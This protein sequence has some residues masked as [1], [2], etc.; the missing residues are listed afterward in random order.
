MLNFFYI[1]KSPKE[2]L[3]LLKLEIKEYQTKIKSEEKK[4]KLFYGNI[5]N[6]G[7]GVL[8]I[9]SPPK[10][11]FFESIQD[12]SIIVLMNELKIDKFFITY[13]YL[14][15]GIEPTPKDIKS[16][17]YYIR[18]LVDII[19]PKIIVC[20]GEDSQF[21][22]FKKK[23]LITDYHG[24]QIGEYEGKPILTANNMSYYE[25]RSKFE[26]HSYKE[27]IKKK[28]WELITNKYKEI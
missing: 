10:T 16:F 11:K 18:L 15:N 20:L 1:N 17:G 21:C 28:D 27:E 4:I 12:K 6:F 3:D 22:F 7:S 14:I 13:N 2:Q 5:D 26:N 25:E 9:S 24:K 19:N 23:F 8:I